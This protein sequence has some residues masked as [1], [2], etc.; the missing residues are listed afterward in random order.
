MTKTKEKQSRI[1]LQNIK[2]PFLSNIN[3]CKLCHEKKINQDLW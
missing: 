2:I 1:P 3:S